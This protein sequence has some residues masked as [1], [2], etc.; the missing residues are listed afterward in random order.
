[1]NSAL[2]PIRH[3]ECSAKGGT[4]AFRRFTNQILPIPP[5]TQISRFSSFRSEKCWKDFFPT[6]TAFYQILFSSSLNKYLWSTLWLHS[7][8]CELTDCDVDRVFT[9]KIL[10]LSSAVNFALIML[11]NCT[12]KRSDNYF[13]VQHIF[14]FYP[15]SLDRAVTWALMLAWRDAFKFRQSVVSLTMSWSWADRELTVI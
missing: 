3:S 11:N 1:M 13:Y 12:K 8:E 10:V 5:A 9:P 14:E 4:R 2:C 6:T 15:R 7:V